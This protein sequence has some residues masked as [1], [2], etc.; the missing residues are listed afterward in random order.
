MGHVQI[1]EFAKLIIHR[2]ALLPQAGPRLSVTV[3]LMKLPDYID[4]VTS[5]FSDSLSSSSSIDDSAPRVNF[6]HLPP[7]D[8]TP[9]WSTMTR[10]YFTHNLVKSQK[11]NVADFLRQRMPNIAGLVVDMLCTSIIDVAEEFS[12]PSYVFFTS[13]A[14]FLGCMLHCQTL[15]D[16]E[17]QD[18]PELKNSASELSIPCF[19]KPVPPKVLPL[20]LVDKQVWHQR[21]LHHAR[22][23][24]KAKGIIVNTFIE[25]ESHSLNSFLKESAYGVRGVPPVY[26]VGPILNHG[27]SIQKRSSEVLNWL[28]DQP[29]CSVVFLCFGSQ[30]SLREDQVHELARGLELSKTRFLWSLRRQSPDDKPASFPSEYVSHREVL[31]DGF[32]DRT[33]GIGK[34]V[35]WVPQLDVLSHPAVGGFVSHCGWNSVLESLWCGVP[36]ATW[37][38]HAE[39]QTNAFQLVRDLGLAVEITLCYYERGEDVTMVTAGEIERGIREVMDGGSEVRKRVKEMKEKSRM[40]VMEGGSSYV[41]L[42]RVIQYMA[43]NAPSK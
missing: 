4:T 11:S 21:F 24:R 38:L 36:I 6:F 39:Q 43:S 7:T 40:A 1:V 8:P 35:G 17:N 42:E 13:P 37:P 9:E 20:V 28:D 34:V 10:G 3:L 27:S 31:P 16:E 30:G 26:P 14:S 32:L 15:Q 29:A 12:L 23:Y 22:A 18:V 2:Q 19:A 41:S 25:L 5:S 33:A